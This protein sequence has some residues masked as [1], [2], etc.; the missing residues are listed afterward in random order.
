[1]DYISKSD[2][3]TVGGK[4]NKQENEFNFDNFNAKSAEQGKPADEFFKEEKPV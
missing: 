4:N 3:S 1:M 2:F